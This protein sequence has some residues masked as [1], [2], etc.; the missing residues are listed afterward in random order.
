MGTEYLNIRIFSFTT[1][2]R[3]LFLYSNIQEIVKNIQ[4]FSLP[5]D[6]CVKMTLLVRN[7]ICVYRPEV[8]Q[9]EGKY[10]PFKISKTKTNEKYYWC[11]VL[12]VEQ[13]IN[14]YLCAALSH[15]HRTN[16]VC[17]HI[18]KLGL[19]RI[20]EYIRICLTN[21][22]IVISVFDPIPIIHSFFIR[23]NLTLRVADI[24]RLSC[25]S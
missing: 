7:E 13:S 16:W 19:M 4:V 3:I 9:L 22:R 8:H 11:I 20:D 2:I 21:I 18:N 12:I 10:S 6:C 17:G 15:Q 23:I 5:K 14:A 25:I 24:I 1:N